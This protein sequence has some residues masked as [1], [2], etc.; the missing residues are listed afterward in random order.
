MSL[1]SAPTAVTWAMASC[2]M[3]NAPAKGTRPTM[4]P[5]LASTVPARSAAV[6]ALCLA[7]DV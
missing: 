7:P 6:I 4:R 1:T 2:P 3:P 5:M